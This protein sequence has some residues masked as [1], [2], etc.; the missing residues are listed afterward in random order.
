M[1]RETSQSA[2][3]RKASKRYS[4]IQPF[5]NLANLLP[6]RTEMVRGTS[7]PHVVYLLSNN[8]ISERDLPTINELCGILPI[9][10]ARKAPELNA[11]SART[12]LL[13]REIA[14]IDQAKTIL[15]TTDFGEQFLVGPPHPLKR[16]LLETVSTRF[17]RKFPQGA[18]RFGKNIILRTFR[19]K[20][21]EN[22]YIYE[23]FYTYS[24]CLKQLALMARTYTPRGGAEFYLVQPATRIDFRCNPRIQLSG[25]LFRD[26][27][28][29]V[30]SDQDLR[31][32]IRCPICGQF[33]VAWRLD[34]AACSTK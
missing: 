33:F 30:I 5:I 8:E 26:G 12:A 16:E 10:R 7:V 9:E 32:F 24:Q 28:L 14:G 34:K 21:D 23:L 29:K 13:L 20:I 3:I 15:C 6:T 2:R 25:D 18:L 31:R 17:K 19:R 4:E 11:R 27:F 1:T 22:L